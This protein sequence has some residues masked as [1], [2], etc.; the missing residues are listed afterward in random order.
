MKAYGGVDVKIHVFLTS[1][2]DGDEWSV[3]R[4]GHFTPGNHWT[5]HWVGHRTGLEEVY[6]P[7]RD[8]NSDPYAVQS[9]ISC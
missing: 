5:G 3:S 8:W 6:S 2:L 7:Y 9:I 1:A 4:P